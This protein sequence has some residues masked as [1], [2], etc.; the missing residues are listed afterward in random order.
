MLQK[1]IYSLT[2]CLI[3]ALSPYFSNAQTSAEKKAI[4]SFSCGMTWKDGM[5]YEQIKNSFKQMDLFD[6]DFNECDSG[7]CG[8]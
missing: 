5:T 4:K 3:F 1:Y 6:S 2:F 8:L 7:Y